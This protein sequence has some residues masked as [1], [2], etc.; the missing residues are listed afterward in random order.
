GLHEVVEAREDRPLRAAKRG[1]AI[2]RHELA[3]DPDARELHVRDL[4][5]V[6]ERPIVADEE[7][8]LSADGPA[9]LHGTADDDRRDEADE[10]PLRDRADV[11]LGHSSKRTPPRSRSWRGV[12]SCDASERRHARGTSVAP[13]GGMRHRHYDA[14]YDRTGYE[15]EGRFDRQR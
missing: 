11:H 10:E 14:G 8:G 5:D 15:R 12:T 2:D 4:V 13:P 7:R 3:R 6:A 9:G 1:E